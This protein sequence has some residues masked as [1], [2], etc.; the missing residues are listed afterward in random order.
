[1]RF[2]SCV[3]V[4]SQYRC[5]KAWAFTL[6]SARWLKHEEALRFLL[7]LKFRKIQMIQV[8]QQMELRLP[9]QPMSRRRKG[10]RLRK[11]ACWKSN[12]SKLKVLSLMQRVIV[13]RK[14]LG[15]E[16]YIVFGA[17][18][19]KDYVYTNDSQPLTS[20]DIGAR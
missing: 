3:V 7:V 16:V 5:R 9:V 10:Q 18:L 11:R 1:L 13:S 8:G 19:R 4:I 17:Q 12:L 2:R 15:C 14:Q 20:N 6:W